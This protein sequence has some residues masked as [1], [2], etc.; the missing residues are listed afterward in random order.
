MKLLKI[1]SSFLAFCTPLKAEQDPAL[2]D[3]IERLNKELTVSVQDYA[4][5]G[6]VD[7]L[8]SLLS[9]MKT[10][11]KYCRTPETHLLGKHHNVTLQHLENFNKRTSCS[12]NYVS[13]VFTKDNNY[14]DVFV[15]RDKACSD[16]NIEESNLKYLANKLLIEMATFENAQSALKTISEPPT[17][18]KGS[19]IWSCEIE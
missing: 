12:Q 17:V 4:N 14:E 11:D 1:V 19:F 18:A 2:N 13:T 8:A 5:S 9:F 3:K 10:Y 6:Q 16:T 15:D 7:K